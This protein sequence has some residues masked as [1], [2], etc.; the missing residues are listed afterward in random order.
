MTQEEKQKRL[1]ALKNLKAWHEVMLD[2]LQK[3]APDNEEIN[4]ILEALFNVI[5]E[6]KKLEQEI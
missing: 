3:V 5:E 1:Q 2:N 6:I 4:T